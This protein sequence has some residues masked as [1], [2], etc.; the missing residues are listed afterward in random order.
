MLASAE[1]SRT[2]GGFSWLNDPGVSSPAN[3]LAG[4]HPPV[5]GW[6]GYLVRGTHL[7]DSCH[8]SY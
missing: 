4:G 2:K 1:N 8:L 7:F 5:C 3:C 6:P